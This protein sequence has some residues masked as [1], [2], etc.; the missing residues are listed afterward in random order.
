M[1]G[2]I[3]KKEWLDKILDGSKIWEIRGH[4]TK[5][6]GRIALIQSRSGT[7][8]GTCDLIQVW[9]P[10]S[11]C[12]MINNYD[13]HYVPPATL[14]YQLIYAWELRNVKAFKKPVPYKHPQGA[15]IWVKLEMEE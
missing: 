3:I 7:I 8:V 15:V 1:H 4:P 2:L 14:E 10:L 5:R 13:C 11:G 6:R 9:G 12:E